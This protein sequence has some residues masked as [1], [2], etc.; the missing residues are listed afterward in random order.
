MDWKLF[1]TVFSTVFLAEIGDKTQLATM[2]FASDARHGKATVLLASMAAL[3][4]AAA[5]GVLAG[6]YVGKFVSP[7]TLR[8]IAG[9]GFIAIGV[10]T[11]ARPGE[12][13]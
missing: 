9:V 7:Q 10:W 4:V 6:T 8:W 2:L 12:A 13:G 5:I 1:A 11:L 3:C